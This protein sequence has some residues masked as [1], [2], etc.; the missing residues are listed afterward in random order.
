MYCTKPGSAGRSRQHTVC[1]LLLAG[2]VIRNLAQAIPQRILLLVQL[3]LVLLQ[4]DLQGIA[5][6]VNSKQPC[7]CLLIEAT[8]A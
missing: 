1:E 8:E 6:D 2:V 4:L 3:L 5:A 7:T